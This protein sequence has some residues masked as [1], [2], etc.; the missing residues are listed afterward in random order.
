MCKSV[1]ALKKVTCRWK[2]SRPFCCPFR[3]DGFQIF[4]ATSSRC[5]C[6]E[7][8]FWTFGEPRAQIE[9]PRRR[10]PCFRSKARRERRSN[11]TRNFCSKVAT[12]ADVRRAQVRNTPR[13]PIPSGTRHGCGDRKRMSCFRTAPQ[14]ERQTERETFHAVRSHRMSFISQRP[15]RASCSRCTCCSEQAG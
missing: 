2:P 13:Q 12:S 7:A 8:S 14:A 6:G 9:H 10:C 5:F 4:V 15:R 1:A 11:G 3:R